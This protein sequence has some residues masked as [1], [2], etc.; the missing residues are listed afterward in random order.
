M[1]DEAIRD[2]ADDCGIAVDWI[3]AADRPQRVSVE[4]LRQI[5]KALD[6]PSATPA[7][8]KEGRERLRAARASQPLLTATMGTPT[9]LPGPAHRTAELVLEDGTRRALEL[10]DGTIPAIDR[11]G[12][13]RLRFG[14][15][16][17]GLAVA[18]QRC[19]TI[20]DVTGGQRA[21]GVAVQLYSL[22][23]RGDGGIGDTAALGP[24]VREAAAHG[25]DAVALSPIHSLFPDDPARYSPYAPSSRL[26]LNPLLAAPGLPSALPDDG[27]L[28]D[29][30]TAS[31]AKYAL[32]RRQFDAFVQKGD[33]DF[34]RFVREGAADLA[35]HAHFEAERS[36][37]PLAY[38]L[39]L[40]WIADRAF[41]AAQ[42][43][44]RRA[45]MRIGLISDL[46][47]GVDPTGSQVATQPDAFLR[48]VTIGAPPDAFN[49]RGQGWGLTS[50][51]PWSLIEHGFAPFL[52]T[53]RAA[54]RHAGGVRIDHAMGLMRL[55]LVPDGASPTEGAYLA[56]PLRD[57]LRL[58]ALESHRNRAVVI[59]E[60]LGTVPRDFRR[61]CRDA[62]IAGMDVMWFARGQWRADSVAMTSTHDLP[63]VAGWWRGADLELRKGLGLVGA[64]EIKRRPADR[65]ALW[66]AFVDA[67]VAAGRAP[68]RGKPERAVDAACG[69]VAKAADVLALLPLEDVLGLTEQPNLPGTTDEHP[70]WR[71][72]LAAPAEELLKAPRVRKRLALVREHRK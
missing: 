11:P 25:A 42:A 68:P 27:M 19:L 18:P 20:G 50:F 1:S 51:S 47:V 8:C 7:Q 62:G 16:E 60:D 21:W 17:L 64:G 31:T 70:N 49:A 29:W 57:L 33:S 34:D 67:G 2:L 39:F 66:K 54:M 32:L 41:A 69:F 44:A 56:Y 35:Q 59:G 43:D 6:L 37:Q 53:V 30:P 26:F 24:L 13:H 63:T 9:S 55:W 58:L 28:I 45:G 22:R 71:R 36:G 61:H 23:R 38:H 15:R 14:D 48:G 4:S 10:L 5:L 65:A 40:Q 46:A 3:D 12:Y 52:A 72:R